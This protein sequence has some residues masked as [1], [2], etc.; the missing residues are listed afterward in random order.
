LRQTGRRQSA[1][2]RAGCLPGLRAADTDDGDGGAAG[3]RRRGE[4]RVR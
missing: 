1:G 3:R 2:K 4:N